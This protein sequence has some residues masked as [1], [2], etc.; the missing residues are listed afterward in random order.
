MKSKSKNCL[1][2]VQGV[3]E[4]IEVARTFIKVQPGTDYDIRY[5]LDDIRSVEHPL[6]MRVS[7]EGN[8]SARLDF[9]TDEQ[10]HNQLAQVHPGYEAHVT[11]DEPN[12]NYKYL[13]QGMFAVSNASGLRGAAIAYCAMC[14]DDSKSVTIVDDWKVEGNFP[15]VVVLRAVGN[16]TVVINSAMHKKDL[17]RARK[18][19]E[20]WD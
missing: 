18:A 11:F 13:D 15:C 7:D 6:W 5:A 10:L 8:Q 16:G 12:A 19:L 14:H 1:F 4:A 9:F 3:D 20:E 2:L 17:K